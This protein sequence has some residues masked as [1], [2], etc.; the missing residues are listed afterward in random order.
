[1]FTIKQQDLNVQEIQEIWDEWVEHHPNPL[2]SAA[3]PNDPALMEVILEDVIQK[4]SLKSGETFLDAGCG[5]GFMLNEIGKKISLKMTGS[6]ISVKQIENAKKCF[7]GIEFFAAPI[8]SLPFPD[9]SFDKILCYSTLTYCIDWK[10]SVDEVL[11]VCRPGG[12]VL[13]ADLAAWNR[14]F[15]FYWSIL[16]SVPKVLLNWGRL[17]R[18]LTWKTKDCP[19]RWINMDELQSYLKE[20][21]NKSQVLLQPKNRQY[22]CVSYRYRRDLLVEKP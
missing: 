7:P 9:G 11:R 19:W 4:L 16:S 3:R 5:S 10:K 21:G 1:M 8:E 20:K 15:F 2:E 14:R 17:K 6:D 22:G 18:A 12:K 13:F